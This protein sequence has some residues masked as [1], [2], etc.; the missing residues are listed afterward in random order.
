MAV[1]AAKNNDPM[2]SARSIDEMAKERVG[3]TVIDAI[4]SSYGGP[5]MSLLNN[6]TRFYGN[7]ADLG[8]WIYDSR[9]QKSNDGDGE[10]TYIEA[11]RTVDEEGE[12]TYIE[13]RRT[14]DDD[15]TPVEQKDT[16]DES[17]KSSD[18]DLDEMAGEFIL[19][20]WGNG[21][22]RID[23]MI[24]AGYSLDDY[25]KIQQRVNEAYE[26][27]RNLHELTN[28]ANEKLKYW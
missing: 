17:E 6:G 16:E 3:N 13:G 5:M 15:N 14:V 2:K 9:N 12:P 7:V 21:Q 20:A 26:S 27:G 19:G 1:G 11:S 23:N 18:Y 10:P 8:R 22:D 24:N 4:A 28:K 25:N